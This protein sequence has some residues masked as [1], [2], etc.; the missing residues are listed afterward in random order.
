[1]SKEKSYMRQVKKARYRTT[2]KDDI[3]ERHASD[4]AVGVVV[5]ELVQV[6]RGFLKETASPGS[7]YAS[8]L[9]RH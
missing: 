4:T 6:C 5:T 7:G 2:S 1:M 8:R 9:E 3:I